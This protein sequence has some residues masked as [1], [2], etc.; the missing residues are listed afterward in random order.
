MKIE[1]D[2]CGAKYSIADEKVRGKTFKIRCKKCSNVII[3]RDKA[4]AASAAAGT[5]AEQVDPGWHLAIN[6]ETVG[7]M[8][9][10]DVRLRYQSGEIDR[11]TAAWQEGF[12]DWVPLS[13]VAVFAD[14]LRVPVTQAA[15][16]QSGPAEAVDDPYASANQSSLS[17]S[18][19]GGLSGGGGLA[20]GLAAGGLGSSRTVITPSND[21]LAS[22]SERPSASSR[23]T[24][25]RNENSVLFSLDSLQSLATRK[26]AAASASPSNA[27]VGTK[28]LATV[29]P[30]SEGSGLI[31]IRALGSM[32]NRSSPVAA[33]T[34]ASA[35]LNDASLPSFSGA[36][37]GG[38]ASPPLL[39]PSL[40]DPMAA[41]PPAARSNLP[42]YI[43][44]VLLIFA[45]VGLA[46]LFVTRENTPQIVER[47]VPVA[48]SVAG[49]D[50]KDKDDEKD[51]DK[52]SDKEDGEEEPAEE[53]GAS[54]DSAEGDG[55]AAASSKGRRAASGKKR[56]ASSSSKPSG[57]AAPK[58]ED[59]GLGDLPDLP[60][61]SKTASKTESSPAP[62]AAKDLEVDCILD[63]S[64]CGGGSKP[65]S[66]GSSKKAEEPKKA[67][68]VD[69]N[70]P[71]S[72]SPSDIR[73]GVD[74]VKDA[75]KACGPKHGAEAGT[76]VKIKLSIAGDSGKVT[77]AAAQAPHAGTALG[78]CVAAALKK[79]SFKKFQ[80][81][82]I[83]A[84]Y[85]VRM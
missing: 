75:A 14:L 52:G 24:G 33:A 5:A 19:L 21:P 36:G 67:A 58:P 22:Y 43:I 51:D 29:A 1:C 2:K 73:D 10:S 53:E 25:Q 82:S 71:A 81:A 50:D 76:S 56:T 28:G 77:S 63:P 68:A 49:A 55:D 30:S 46:V 16:M 64:K 47:Q 57:S 69:P 18:S 40:P 78:N 44:L 26:P 27:F 6:G 32:V 39:S 4:A 38:L 85:P 34:A 84:V 72:L 13:E 42:L 74:S 17:P 11:E 8:S 37:L 60:T 62:S 70:L 79:A 41:A 35:G 9:E 23:L 83:G 59:D 54:P 66:S 20:A 65:S 3:V 15:P 80:K 45:V 31:D 48:P 61:A 12:E 7:P